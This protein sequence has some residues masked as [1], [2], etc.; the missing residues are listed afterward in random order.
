VHNIINWYIICYLS[1][2]QIITADFFFDKKKLNLLFHAFFFMPEHY[3]SINF[4]EFLCLCIKNGEIEKKWK[5]FVCLNWSTQYWSIKQYKN[6]RLNAFLTT[7]KWI[8]RTFIT[9]EK[10]LSTKLRKKC[11]M[12]RFKVFFNIH[13]F[14]F[15]IWFYIFY[16]LDSDRDPHQ[17][18]FK[19]IRAQPPFLHS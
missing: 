10:L 16:F 1:S 9:D 8:K 2:L 19:L 17:A 11:R 7:C 15:K 18:D 4:K 6:W 14:T 13:S 3:A 12:S 5:F